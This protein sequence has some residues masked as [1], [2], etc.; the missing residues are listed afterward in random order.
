MSSNY[1]SPYKV[2]TVGFKHHVFLD[3]DMYYSPLYLALGYLYK[4]IPTNDHYRLVEVLNQNVLMMQNVRTAEIRMLMAKHLSNINAFLESRGACDAECIGDADWV[5]MNNKYHA[6]IAYNG[7]INHND[8]EVRKTPALLPV[9]IEQIKE[10]A[11]IFKQHLSV[12]SL[13]SRGL[14][15]NNKSL[16]MNNQALYYSRSLLGETYLNKSDMSIEKSVR[17]IQK[18]CEKRKLRPM[19]ERALRKKLTQIPDIAIMN[20][21]GLKGEAPPIHTDMGVIPSATPST[22]EYMELDYYKEIF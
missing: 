2:P 8:S 5:D 12:T 9:D 16:Y 4:H 20:T 1:Q 15:Y 10:W 14:T 21:K 19:D 22:K 13:L 18:A 7:H 6:V 17:Y 11:G 3:D